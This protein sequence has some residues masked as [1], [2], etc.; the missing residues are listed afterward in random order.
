MYCYFER[1]EGTKELKHKD[2]EE[3]KNKILELLT[4]YPFQRAWFIV[5]EV[6]R[7]LHWRYQNRDLGDSLPYDEVED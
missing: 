5:Q 7:D 6:N 4:P 3:T 1:D 2:E